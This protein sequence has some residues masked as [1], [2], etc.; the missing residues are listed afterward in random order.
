MSTEAVQ[1]ATRCDGQWRRQL[2]RRLLAWYGRN[3]RDLPWR[4]TRDPYSVWVS[5]IM[6]QQTQVATV[7]GY[8][9]RFLA[10]FPTIDALAAAPQEHVLRLWE[11]LG[12]YRR[13]RQLHAAAQVLV[14]EHGGRFPAVRAQVLAL[15]G[16]GRYTA[17]AILSIAF[18]QPEPILEANTFRLLSRLIA[19]RENPQSP[20][21]RQILWQLAEELV[22]ARGA[23]TFNQA[24]MELGGQVCT[25][26]APRCGQ[27]PLRSL[28]QAQQSGLQEETGRA[29]VKPPS[30]AVREAAIVVRRGRRVLLVERGEGGRWAG[31][32]DFPR[33]PLTGK[34]ADLA[35]E[36]R[37][38]LG[39]RYGLEVA[40]L[41]PL[42]TLKHS[43]TRFRITLMCYEA[44]H[45]GGKPAG[46]GIA[47]SRWLRPAEL[48]DFPL[49]VTG[50]KL[51]RLL[52]RKR[53]GS[54]GAQ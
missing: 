10:A 5:E 29:A 11:G 37:Q 23:G 42:V 4:R 3:A 30:T 33:F 8:F 52:L 6:L 45:I 2:R 47:A 44:Q 31:L 22:P 17:G 34:P 12:Y 48:A 25:P 19:F 35:D 43:V 39:D 50:R 7:E 36:A 40:P 26:R 18:D 54:S 21:G 46:E 53:D 1:A 13:A 41:E 49:N 32:W 27:C 51:A 28:C 24:L 9:Q 15:P 16:I 20:A 38:T 14:R